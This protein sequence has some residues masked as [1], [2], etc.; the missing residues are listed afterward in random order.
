MR[1]RPR[2]SASLDVSDLSTS[3]R[4]NR[5]RACSS[6]L[7]PSEFRRGGL[8][9][10]SSNSAP[11][12]ASSL[13]SC[14]VIA[15]GV[16]YRRSAAPAIDPAWAN[17]TRA[18]K[19]SNKETTNSRIVPGSQYHGDNYEAVELSVLRH[20]EWGAG[21]GDV[22]ENDSNENDCV[23]GRDCGSAEPCSAARADHAGGPVQG[24]RDAVRQVHRPGAGHGGEI[25]LEAR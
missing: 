6:T 12:A 3:V 23:R 24:G 5:S 11:S 9:E 25:R 21:K 15:D 22:H 1:K 19:S 13:C 4:C 2:G 17:S 16:R 20:K 10:R 14:R 7:E 18:R 8:T